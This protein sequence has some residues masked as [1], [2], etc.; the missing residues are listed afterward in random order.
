MIEKKML[1]TPGPVMTSDKVKAVLA[2]PDM[3]HRRPIFEQVV[4]SVRA[5]LLKLFRADDRYTTVVVSGS[6]TAAN[7]TALSSIIKDSDEILLIKNGEFG[8][9]L[10]GILTCYHYTFHKLEYAWGQLPDMKEVENALVKN[11]DIQ[12]ICMV[13]HETS[14]GMI[15]P[16]NEV[17]ELANKYGRKL[18]VDSVSAIGGEDI[19]VVRDHID[20]CTGV[21][22]K[23]V[24]GM[25]GASF[26]CAKRSS[27]PVLGVEVPRRNIYLNLQKHIEWADKCSQTPNTPSVTMFV[28]LDAALQELFEE[29]LENRIKRY[30]TCAKII[31]DGVRELGL[32]LLLPDELSSNTVTS[33]FLPEGVKLADFVD[34]LDRRGYVVYPGKGHF[35]DRNMFQIANMGQIEPEHCRDFLRVLEET[36]EYMGFERHSSKCD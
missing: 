11:K 34:E 14:T 10:D 29:G 20:V 3:S 24:C 15:N 32:R 30:Q 22:N 21:P 13:Y 19:D 1:F 33:V 31:R 27:V 23:A 12:W 2:H 35:Y 16:V 8:K 4:D 7:E 6:G 5:K 9:R 17:G 26:I 25:T 18:F 36:L 28:A